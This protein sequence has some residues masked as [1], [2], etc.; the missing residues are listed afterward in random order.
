MGF[1]ASIIADGTAL[2][3]GAPTDELDAS[4]LQTAIEDQREHIL[5]VPGSGDIVGCCMF[6]GV[7]YAWRNNSAGTSCDM[8]RSTDTGW[9]KVD[10]GHK[11]TFGSG[12]SFP[13]SFS[14]GFSNGFSYADVLVI[15]D[16]LLG[17]IS[18]ATCVVTYF[19]FLSGDL[20]EG[21]AAADVYFS[22]HEGT[23]IVGE[24][25][26]AVRVETNGI[27]VITAAN[28]DVTF[29]AN[30]HYELVINNFFGSSDLSRMYG[31][32]G[33]GKGFVTDGETV[34]FINTGMVDDTPG[35]VNVH[36]NHLFYSF[37]G[38]SIQHSSV[39]DPTSFSVLLGAGEI[40]I[41]DDC[42]G[43]M[44]VVGSELSLLARNST[45]ILSGTSSA[46]WVLNNHSRESGCIEWSLQKM[47]SPL[48][49]DDRGV[50]NLT[51]VQEYGDFK[52]AV[53][54]D[55]VQPFLDSRTTSVSAS[56][57]VKEKNQYRLFFEDNSAL[58]MTFKDNKLVGST[59][60][61]LS[62]RVVSTW[63]GEDSTGK[64]V[65][66]FGST[67][68][69]L[70]QMDSGTSEDG[71]ALTSGMR[72]AFHHYGYPNNEKRFLRITTEIKTNGGINI[73]MLPDFTYS[74]INA[75]DP[76]NTS[77]EVSGGGMIWDTI[78]LWDTKNWDSPPSGEITEHIDGHGRYM[79]VLY[80][81]SS[82]YEQPFTINGL[83]VE[84][85]TK[86]RR[87]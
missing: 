4:Y 85:S 61:D 21:T 27:G 9:V 83:T 49:L 58:Y 11:I 62:K 55:L 71:S 35:H 72:L 56:M 1:V 20:D 22:E 74:D 75:P 80:S 51:A 39:T 7:S 59:V 44:P 12:S 2:E 42:T 53:I 64:E 66:L 14:S 34:Q 17:R 38:G 57:R 24:E 68:G 70:Y 25:I 36:Y 16:K 86:N 37:P 60:I 73:E 28:S 65:L 78:D 26:M 33:V 3:R 52:D 67:D 6:D 82:I 15:G 32:N 40:G 87:R 41:G 84:F 46:D 30:G 77:Y 47:S 50:T 23:F 48:Y 69:Y 79:G 76:L 19:T 45:Y 5:P 81:H 8:Y 43:I 31:V 18:G 29:P 63:A 10:L 13:E 54:S